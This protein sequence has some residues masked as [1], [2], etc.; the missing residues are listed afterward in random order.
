MGS[1]QWA[2]DSGRQAGHKQLLLHN[3][4]PTHP[5]TLVTCAGWTGL[6]IHF[7]GWAELD[8]LNIF[9]VGLDLG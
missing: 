9:L 8:H 5:C 2:V 6:F 7:A 4:M 1:G 3:D